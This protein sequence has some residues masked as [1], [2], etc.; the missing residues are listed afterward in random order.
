MRKFKMEIDGYSMGHLEYDDKYGFT[1]YFDK[2]VLERCPIS[3]IPAMVHAY[4]INNKYVL[5]GY[6]AL[7]WV[8]SRIMPS[9]RQGVNETLRNLGLTEYSEVEML[10]AFGCNC[11]MDRMK[12]YEV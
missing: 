11:S 6:D 4:V 5:K 3:I 9:N 8:R 1:I 2:D 10:V 7:S 12:I